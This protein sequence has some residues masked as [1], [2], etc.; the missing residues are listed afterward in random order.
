VNIRTAFRHARRPG[1]ILLLW[2]AL[3]V[4]CPPGKVRAYIMPSEQIIALMLGNFSKFQTLAVSRSIRLITAEDLEVQVV[5]NEKVWVKS[6]GYFHSELTSVTPDGDPMET[7]L[8]SE[9]RY[10]AS[11][12]HGLFLTTGKEAVMTLLSEMG[13]NLESV[14]FTRY[15]GR[16]VYRLGNPEADA[17]K[18]LIEKDRFL[19]R[20]LS[21]QLW[22]DEGRKAVT[23]RFN[24]YRP[25]DGGWYPYEVAVYTG[26]NFQERAVVTELE[27]NP[28]IDVSFFENRK[29]FKIDSEEDRIRHVIELLKE[30]YRQTD[31]SLHG[32]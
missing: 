32:N 9:R 24:D 6:P 21:Y 12:F 7:A 10:T 5:L 28:P 8:L 23:V 16:I 15:D 26:G 29:Q 11:P 1:L 22:T 19:P 3:S 14:A 20:L 27:I 13:V 25:A 31:S 18:L 30:K 17:P 4:W 2:A